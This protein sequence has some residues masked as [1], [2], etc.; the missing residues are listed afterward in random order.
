MTF[1]SRLLAFDPWREEAHRQR[2]SALARAGQ[3][4]AA[5]AQYQTCR[6]IL[7]KELGVEPSAETTA[8]YEQIRNTENL[9]LHNLPANTTSFVGRESELAE[10]SCQIAGCRL[11][12]INFGRRRRRGQIPFGVAS[13]TESRPSIFRR[14]LVYPA[15]ISQRYR[16]I[17]F[18]HCQRAQNECIGRGSN[19]DNICRI[20]IYYSSWTA[21]SI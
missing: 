3:R 8:L 7:D 21:W 12:G 2:M 9:S 20:K 6:R 19:Q 5:L 16:R 4:S 14:R 13:R 10:I 17:V 11:P 18:V 1:A 15:V